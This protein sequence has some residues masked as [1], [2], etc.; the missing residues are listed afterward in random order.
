[1]RPLNRQERLEIDAGL[2]AESRRVMARGRALFG[3]PEL[4]ADTAADAAR[5]IAAQ[6][7]ALPPGERLARRREIMT[8]IDDLV[9]LNERLAS[10]RDV[11]GETIVRLTRHR[12]VRNA[13]VQGAS[14]CRSK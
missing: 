8:V 5:H 10:E 4:T 3:V 7:A 9:V 1:M 12:A 14:I 13:Y 11:V 6:L 2:D